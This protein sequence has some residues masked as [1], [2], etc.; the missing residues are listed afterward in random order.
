[1]IAADVMSLIRITLLVSVSRDLRHEVFC[2]HQPSVN[3]FNL[4]L[5][6]HVV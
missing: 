5:D 3:I 1:M 6:Y 4:S 2:N